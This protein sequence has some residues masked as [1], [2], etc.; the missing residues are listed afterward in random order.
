M[1]LIKT[2]GGIF[3]AVFGFSQ[4]CFS[5]ST[6]DNSLL[7]KKVSVFI[8]NFSVE[9][10]LNYL[11]VKSNIPIGFVEAK[12]SERIQKTI[13]LKI[14]KGTV[15]NILNKI[16]EADNRYSWSFEQ[17]IINVY[18]KESQFRLEEIQLDIFEINDIEIEEIHSIIFNHPKVKSEIVKHN[19]KPSLGV[20]YDGPL[21][22]NP[23]VKLSFR[24]KKIKDILNKLL[25]DKSVRF[26]SIT[27][28]GDKNELISIDLFGYNASLPS[29]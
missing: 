4:I 24:H 3:I 5:Q 17:G 21:R 7:N 8:D 14:I 1:N 27:N 15:E 18:P 12:D 29:L 19:L 22:E 11:S 20:N 10:S 9:S 25:I 26:W 2:L 6:I 13:S 23:R 28:F 16:V